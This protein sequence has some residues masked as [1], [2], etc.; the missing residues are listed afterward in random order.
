MLAKGN[1]TTQKKDRLESGSK[2]NSQS[3]D[4]SDHDDDGQKIETNHKNYNNL[5]AAIVTL[6]CQ[7]YSQLSF[8]LLEGESNSSDQF[9]SA[10]L[11]QSL[12]NLSD[13][14]AAAP[15]TTTTNNIQVWR[16]VV[17]QRLCH[18]RYRRWHI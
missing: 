14:T 5:L 4:N 7:L 3:R 17:L 15:P 9:I 18:C 12:I 10:S 6:S 2:L 16:H 8:I 1:S 13:S 11:S